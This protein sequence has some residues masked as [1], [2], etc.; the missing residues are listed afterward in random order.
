MLSIFLSWM[1]T[2][3]NV[4]VHKQN[5]YFWKALLAFTYANFLNSQKLLFQ[6]V[7]VDKVV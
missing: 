4:R 3:E 2:I 1:A 7:S 5:Q 6:K